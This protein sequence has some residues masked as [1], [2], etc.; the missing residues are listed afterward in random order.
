MTK[1]SLTGSQENNCQENSDVLQNINRL[2]ENV[3]IAE[4]ETV[5]ANQKV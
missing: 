2:Y 4:N 1:I 5:K 3:C